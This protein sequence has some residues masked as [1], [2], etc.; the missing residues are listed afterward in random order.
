MSFH[1]V[2]GLLHQ[3]RIEQPPNHSVSSI[4]NSSKTPVNVHCKNLGLS[5]R[6]KRGAGTHLASWLQELSFEL[7]HVSHEAVHQWLLSEPD[8]QTETV[9][10]NVIKHVGTKSLGHNNPILSVAYGGELLVTKD[11]KPMRLWRA[12][13]ATLLRVI[14]GCPGD[15]VS[16]SPSRQKIVT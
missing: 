7:S 13:D 14:S 2:D 9:L 5:G 1:D 10:P 3:E 12:K 6:L 16:F 15:T 4:L 11:E 8:P